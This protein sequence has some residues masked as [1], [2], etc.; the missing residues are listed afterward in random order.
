MTLMRFALAP[1]L[2]LAA[3][4]APASSG[5]VVP[6]EYVA[7]GIAAKACEQLWVPGSIESVSVPHGWPR[8]TPVWR[9]TL[10]QG[11]WNVCD[12][13]AAP[14]EY[15]CNG[16]FLAVDKHTGKAGRCAISFTTRN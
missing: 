3:C 6:N 13:S 12:I 11:T 8:L 4:A 9:A 1:L 5:D 10:K 15:G 16:P 2:V 14:N 7:I